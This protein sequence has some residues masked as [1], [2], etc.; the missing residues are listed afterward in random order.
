MNRRFYF[1]FLLM[2]CIIMASFANRAYAVDFLITVETDKPTY[3]MGEVVKIS[4]NMTFDG[5]PVPDALIGLQVNGPTNAYVFRTCYTGQLP[6]ELVGDITGDGVV[7]IFDVVI[8]AKA[9]GSV[10]GGPNWDQRADLNG[11]NKID[12]FDM[13]VIAVHYA[14]VWGGKRDIRLTDVFIADQAGNRVTTARK[15]LHYWIWVN[16]T[17]HDAAMP[18]NVTIGIT[19]YDSTSV[20]IYALSSRV[21]TTPGGDYFVLFDWTVPDEA[22]LGAARVYASA[23][24]KL[25]QDLGRPYCLE[26][27]GAF[28]IVSSFNLSLNTE[29]IITPMQAPTNYSSSF[30]LPSTGASLGTYAVYVSSFYLYHIVPFMTSNSTTFEV[31]P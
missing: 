11:D 2:L 24:S 19:V 28:N 18:L 30:R 21:Q 9:F 3:A 14:Q 29:A 10:L 6:P 8:V 17:S 16:F 25:P 1:S 20:P 13:V 31:T 15:G 5:E 22:E 4:G 7:D 23:Y 27:S 26:K 12:I